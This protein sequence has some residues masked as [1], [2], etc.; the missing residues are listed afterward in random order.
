M[1]SGSEKNSKE[2]QKKVK[3]VEDW[4]MPKP[5]L[6]VLNISINTYGKLQDRDHH[7]YLTNKETF[8]FNKWGN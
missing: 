6:S 4:Y 8:L 5:M 1:N 7:S 3:I 2:G